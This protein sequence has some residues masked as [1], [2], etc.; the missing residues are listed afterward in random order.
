MKSIIDTAL[1]PETLR[2]FRLLQSREETRSLRRVA[3]EMDGLLPY[4]D[5]S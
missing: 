4:L 5:L 1:V 2:P 3:E